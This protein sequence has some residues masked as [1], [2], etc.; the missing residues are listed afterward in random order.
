[1]TR[2]ALATEGK[3]EHWIIKHIVQTFFKSEEIFFRQVQPQVFDDTQEEIGGWFEVLKFCG[4]TDDIRAALVESDYLIIQIDTDESNNPNF[5]VPHTKEGAVA[6][7]NEELYNDVIDK[8]ESIIDPQLENELKNKIIFAVC[9]HSIECWL[10]PIF[11]TNNH[12]TDIRNCLIT[13]N[14]ELRR[15]NLNI[16]PPKK[17]KEKRQIAYSNIL[18][19]LR[20]KSDIVSASIYNK[21]FSNFVSDLNKIEFLV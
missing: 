10:L 12:K 17:Q 3:S 21:G 11:C 13:L 20:R 7:T 9:I 4:R 6:K 8:I 1:M 19:N 14:V 15:K 5:N 2:I 16:I 18:R